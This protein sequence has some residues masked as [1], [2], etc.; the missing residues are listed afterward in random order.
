LLIVTAEIL[1]LG[2]LRGRVS[3]L[4]E[5]GW[6]Q[7]FYRECAAEL[8]PNYT[9]EDFKQSVARHCEALEQAIVW[10][11]RVPLALSLLICQLGLVVG[12]RALKLN[13]QPRLAPADYF[14]PL[15]VASGE[16][17]VVVTLVYLGVRGQWS[18]LL[19]TLESYGERLATG[20]P[21]VPRETGRTPETRP[22]DGAVAPH[23]PER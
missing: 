8:P 5:G 16:A 10:R 21:T 6:P 18:R 17:L 7:Q 4:N 2:T 9:P 22:G 14:L 3:R 13:P 23:H 20:S 19:A 11:W 1:R 15:W 12:L